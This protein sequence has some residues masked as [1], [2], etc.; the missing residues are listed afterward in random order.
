[1]ILIYETSFVTIQANAHFL[2]EIRWTYLFDDCETFIFFALFSFFSS[3]VF[4]HN[5]V[6]KTSSYYTICCILRKMFICCKPGC[7]LFIYY[8]KYK[9]ECLKRAH[10]ANTYFDEDFTKPLNTSYGGSFFL[11]PDESLLCYCILEIFPIE[12]CI[13]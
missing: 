7:F 13:F 6:D 9:K 2:T 11:Q 3:S 12:V 8:N 5:D 10:L 1:M 4:A